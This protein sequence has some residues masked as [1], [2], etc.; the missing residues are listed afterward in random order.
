MSWT[1]GDFTISTFP[2][3]P[4]EVESSLFTIDGELMSLSHRRRFCDASGLPLFD[5]C[6]NKTGV[7]WFARLPGAPDN[8]EPIAIVAP[9]FYPLKDKIDVYVRNAAANGEEEVLQVRGLDVWKIKTH[10]YLN[11]NLAMVIER[12]TKLGIYVGK[13]PEWI[14]Q[15]AQGLDLLLVPVIISIM[16]YT[17]Y[18]TTS[19][20]SY[21]G[22]H[23]T[24]TDR[25]KSMHV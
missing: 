8:S 20:S 25:R 7:T 3:E 16:A 23:G 1:R 22:G 18:D 13:G 24:E 6:R 4:G 19:G 17:M 10:V 11:G 12:K 21:T 9:R 2:T 15:V 5:L 14:V